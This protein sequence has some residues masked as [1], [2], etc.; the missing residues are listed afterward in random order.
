MMKTVTVAAATTGRIMARQDEVV[1][2]ENE[3]HIT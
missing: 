1:T 2:M 3:D